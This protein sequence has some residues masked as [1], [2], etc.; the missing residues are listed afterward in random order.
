MKLRNKTTLHKI[1]LSCLG[2]FLVLKSL[3][4]YAVE[5][6]NGKMK[7]NLFVPRLFPLHC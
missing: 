7:H 1:T 3:D 6:F 2:S 5:D 4:R